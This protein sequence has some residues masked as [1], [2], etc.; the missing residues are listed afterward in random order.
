MKELENYLDDETAVAARQHL[1]EHL[2]RCHECRVLVDSTRKTIKIMTECDSFELPASLSQK[3]M[4][5]INA[6]KP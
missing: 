5:R 6:G 2:S 3:I 4:A 1:E